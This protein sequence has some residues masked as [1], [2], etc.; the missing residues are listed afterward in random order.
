[1]GVSLNERSEADSPRLEPDMTP[2]VV[3]EI[4]DA[5]FE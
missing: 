4:K 5:A 1:M 2:Q 3:V